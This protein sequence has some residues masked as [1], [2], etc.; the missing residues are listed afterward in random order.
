[1]A[2]SINQSQLSIL[3]CHA[4]YHSTLFYLLVTTDIFSI[5][6]HMATQ[7]CTLP[8]SYDLESIFDDSSSSDENNT[9]ILFSTDAVADHNSRAGRPVPCL[10]NLDCIGSVSSTISVHN[11]QC[12]RPVPCHDVP[13]HLTALSADQLE[14]SGVV[15]RIEGS[16]QSIQSSRY[17]A[18]SSASSRLSVRPIG[19]V[20]MTPGHNMFTGTDI[21]PRRTYV[22]SKRSSESS[23][24]RDMKRRKNLSPEEINELATQYCCPNRCLTQI[25]F[26]QV[27]DMRMRHTPQSSDHINETLMRLRLAS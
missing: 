23:V 26:Q 9:G 13:G 5:C 1:M 19:N 4:V 22:S 17:S 3:E 18:N 24:E 6:G 27:S 25:S 15:P 16:M 8:V 12:R 20:L 11:T 21:Q 7:R 10:L 14:S 2:G